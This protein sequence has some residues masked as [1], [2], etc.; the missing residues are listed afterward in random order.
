[1]L[2]CLFQV[3]LDEVDATPKRKK[4]YKSITENSYFLNK[5]DKLAPFKCPKCGEYALF[6][7]VVYIGCYSCLNYFNETEIIEANGDE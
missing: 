6:M 3:P 5:V 4:N 2:I 7:G 1:M